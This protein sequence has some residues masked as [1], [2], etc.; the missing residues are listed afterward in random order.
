MVGSAQPAL[1]SRPA[2]ERGSRPA[3]SRAR[4][5]GSAA[6]GSSPSANR[7]PRPMARRSWPTWRR[8]G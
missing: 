6:G 7:L 4:R 2:P 8:G 3:A 5:C 1:E